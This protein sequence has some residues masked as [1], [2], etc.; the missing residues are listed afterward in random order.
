MVHRLRLGGKQPIDENIQK[1]LDEVF[2][3]QDQAKA[4][5]FDFSSFLAILR[6]K[7][8][9][10]S[11]LKDTLLKGLQEDTR[12]VNIFQEL[13]SDPKTKVVIQVHKKYKLPHKLL[14]VQHWDGLDK[15]CRIPNVP[16]VPNDPAI[17]SKIME[18]VH[19][20]PYDDHL[21][22]RKPFQQLQKNL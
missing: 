15:D 4:N 6:S 13:Q 17:K 22:Y 12:W 14:E 9:L 18:K 8:G 7:I 19:A 16:R 21:G 3:G 20:A 11:Q 2:K 5:S 1:K 10:E